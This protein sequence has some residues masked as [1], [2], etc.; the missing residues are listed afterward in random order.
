MVLSLVFGALFCVGLI[1][2][3]SYFSLANYLRLF[4]FWLLCVSYAGIL[5]TSYLLYV[6][7]LNN[8]LKQ[9]IIHLI[10]V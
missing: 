4:P 1:Q 8:V 3:V 6:F 7:E 10:K 2:M 9:D 5:L